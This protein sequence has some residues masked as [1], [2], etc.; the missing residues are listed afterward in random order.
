[1]AASNQADPHAADGTGMTMLT[2]L[3]TPEQLRAELSKALDALAAEM[4]ENARLRALVP[5]K[6]ATWR[7]REDGTM[8][9]WSPKGTALGGYKLIDGQW[10]CVCR[11]HWIADSEAEARSQVEARVKGRGWIIDNQPK[12]T[13]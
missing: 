2:D 6:R 7:L 13:A 11:W 9:L 10:F 12:E 8:C 4:Q 3:L 5:D 1:M